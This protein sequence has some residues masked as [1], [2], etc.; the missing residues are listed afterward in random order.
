MNTSCQARSLFLALC[1]AICNPLAFGQK[2]YWT[3]RGVEVAPKIQRANLDGSEIET[4][5]E[6]GLGSPYGIA[7]DLVHGKVY[8][9]ELSRIRRANLDGSFVEDVL[10]G[11]D[12]VKGIT[13]DVGSGKMYFV[14]DY[15]HR[16]RRANL[17][18]TELEDI[19][20]RIGPL[21][22]PMSIALDVD[23]SKMYW[24]SRSPC[25]TRQGRIQRANLDGSYVEELIGYGNGSGITLDLVH[26]KMYW[27]DSST[28]IGDIM[29]SNL[30]GSGI[31]RIARNQFHGM[32]MAVDA[33]GA[34]VYWVVTAPV[35]YPSSGI[36]RANLDGSGIETVVGSLNRPFGIALDLRAPVKAAHDIKPGSCPNPLNAQS[37]GVTPIT[38]LG[39]DTLDVINVDLESLSLSRADG[40]GGSL[41]PVLHHHVSDVGTPFYGAACECHVLRGDGIA[42]LNMRFSTQEIVQ[43]LE[44]LVGDHEDVIELIINGRLVDG[45]EFEAL[46]CITL[47]GHANAPKHRRGGR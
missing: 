4:I 30:D 6:A 33:L 26:H 47:V 19:G 15:Y 13:L 28:T 39:T 14:E 35:V 27:T 2:I 42:D 10:A 7:L 34:K 20:A 11:L 43:A 18:G 17:D 25:C 9:A 1:F 16:L 41:R 44:L 21:A 5:V 8:W 38:L 23:E 22:Y 12:G 31:E 32:N 40:V 29:R 45:R 37:E 3:E 46:D 24:I 36:R